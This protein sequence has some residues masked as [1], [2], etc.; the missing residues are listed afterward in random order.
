[1]A[2]VCA[3]YG[4]A[5]YTNSWIGINAL[6]ILVSLMATAAVYSIG[7]LMPDSTR[8]KIAG[9]VRSEMVQLLLSAVII[10]AL[11]SVT[12]FACQITSSISQSVAKTQLNPFQFATYYIGNL[13]FIKGMGLLTTTYSTALTYEIYALVSTQ[14]GI[15]IN[16]YAGEIP[17][18]GQYIGNGYNFKVSGASVIVDFPPEINVGLMFSNLVD[19]LLGIFSPILTLAVSMLL[20][21]YIALPFLQYT[22][23]AVILPIAIAMRSLAFSNGELRNASNAILAIAVA[24][25][26][27]YPLTIAL[28]SYIIG[29]VFSAANPSFVYLHTTYTLN[30]FNPSSFFSQPLPSG[31]SQYSPFGDQI[32]T[33][34]S[35]LYNSVAGAFPIPFAAGTASIQQLVNDIAEFVFTG[36]VLFA[37]DMAITIGFAIGLTKALNAGLE[38]A[39]HFW[40]GL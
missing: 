28:D 38:G 22:G 31:A 9:Y 34:W 13:V 40:A 26:I 2:L 35:L 10:L 19:L 5:N 8:G 27:I 12:F 14:A 3:V 6:V 29:Y 11:I 33:L 24:G 32:G 18:I 23:F 16:D 37:I 25:Y 20:V 21:Q 4:G 36:I 7:R 30:Q 39:Q 1:M 15:F 17:L